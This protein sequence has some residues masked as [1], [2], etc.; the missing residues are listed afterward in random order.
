MKK[1]LLFAFAMCSAAGA[2]AM[3]PLT[4]EQL[5]KLTV[6][7]NDDVDKAFSLSSE[8]TPEYADESN[9]AII[10]IQNF[11]GTGLP[12][13]MNVDWEA[14]T[15]SVTPYTFNSEY[16]EDD[17]MTYYHM[18]VNEE[19]ANLSSPTDPAFSSSKL[20]GTISESGIT[21]NPWN[22][23]VVHPY[24]TSMTKKYDKAVTTKVIAPN[25]TMTIQC[26]SVNWDIEDEN[27]VS[28]IED[29]E[30]LKY[31]VYAAVDGTKLRVYNWDDLP[32]CVELTQ[33]M[34]DG[35]YIYET[36]PASMVYIRNAR[37]QYGIYSFNG[38]DNESLWNIEA[39]ALKS[40]AVTNPNELNFGGW[41]I[42]AIERKQERT[43]GGSAKLTLDTPLQLGTSGIGETV[44]ESE[45]VKVTY[46]NLNGVETAEPAKGIF[47]KVSTY[48]DGSVKA[49]KAVR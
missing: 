36:D 29:T 46:F 42:A 30:V 45:P 18:V 3:E 2:Y 37:Y 22:I 48:A 1:S 28:P 43:I 24:F 33:K 47:V 5:A 39:V 14:G 17:Y 12:L 10:Q 35:Q 11:N 6:Q 23:V 19:A 8:V 44:A 32:S 41:I 27:Y 9:P 13:R 49:E 26:R 16:N 40:E 38:K 15:V 34:V 4:A 21:L 31:G 7:I 25:A 20:T